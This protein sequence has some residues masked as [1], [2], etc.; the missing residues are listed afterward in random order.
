MIDYKTS[1]CAPVVF[2]SGLTPITAG[3]ENGSMRLYLWESLNFQVVILSGPFGWCG[4]SSGTS[5]KGFGRCTRL[6]LKVVCTFRSTSFQRSADK[7]VF[8]TKSTAP[9]LSLFVLKY[10]EYSPSLVKVPTRL[11]D[12]LR[13]FS[14]VKW[15]ATLVPKKGFCEATRQQTKMKMGPMLT[16]K[17]EQNS[18]SQRNLRRSEL[19]HQQSQSREGWRQW[20]R[21][22]CRRG[23]L[24]AV[25]RAG[26]RTGRGHVGSGK[27]IAK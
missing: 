1:V 2:E 7:A 17:S 23:A 11:W 21:G 24:L 12:R 8:N 14:R 6:K 20:P 25:T 9:A 16:R 13:F 18:S 4:S 15:S 27:Q 26:C 19:R 10:K 5:P 3:G 22:G